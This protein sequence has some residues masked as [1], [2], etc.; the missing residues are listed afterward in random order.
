MK[1]QR[2][3]G[4]LWLFLLLGAAVFCSLWGRVPT[5]GAQT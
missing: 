5:K 1:H 3:L 2:L 4:F